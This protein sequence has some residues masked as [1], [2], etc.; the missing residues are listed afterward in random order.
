MMQFFYFLR[1]IVSYLHGFFLGIRSWFYNFSSEITFSQCS[2]LRGF[3]KQKALFLHAK[4]VDED[5]SLIQESIQ[6][7]G[8]ITSG[9]HNG[10]DLCKSHGNQH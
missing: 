3:T 7:T 6:L 4:N 9:N 10:E 8:T 5:F 1:G 2:C